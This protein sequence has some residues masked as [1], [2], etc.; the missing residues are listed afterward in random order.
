MATGDDDLSWRLRAEMTF[1][2]MVLIA[3]LRGKLIS[4]LTKAGF[5]VANA[6]NYFEALLK[7]G[8]IKL[9]TVITDKELPGIVTGRHVLSYGKPSM[10]PSS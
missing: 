6:L 10:L 7:L 1:R 5:E 4:L 3:S 8:E 2:L 9:D